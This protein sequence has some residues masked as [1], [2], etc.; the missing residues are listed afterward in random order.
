[1]T[2]KLSDLDNFPAEC[3]TCE[4]IGSMPVQVYPGREPG[5][6]FVSCDSDLVLASSFRHDRGFTQ[7]LS[8]WT[9]DAE[10]SSKA[11]PAIT[12]LSVPPRSFSGNEANVPLLLVA[13]DRIL[14]AELEPQVRPVQR[15][16]RLEATPLKLLYSHVLRCLV[17]AVQTFDDKTAIRF[18]DPETGDDLSLPSAF[19]N[20]KVQQTEYIS[21]LGRERDRILC[22]EEWHMRPENGSYYYLLISTR[23]TGGD[24]GGRVLVVHPVLEKSSGGV[25]GQVRFHTK[26]KLDKFQGGPGAPISA[27]A[28]S[29]LK[30]V[31]STGANLLSYELDVAAK[32]IVMEAQMDLGGPA[33]KLSILPGGTRTMALVK[34]DSL[35]VVEQ[36][37]EGPE[38]TTTHIEDATRSAMDMLEVAGA[39]EQHGSTPVVADPPQS[40]V[41][42]SDQSCNLTG[43]WVPWNSPGKDCEV[44]FEAELPSSVRRLR[45][46]RTLPAWSRE[47]RKEPKFGLLPASVDNAQI[48]GMGIDGSM[49]SFTL[50]SMDAWRF[51]R[52]VQNLA[53]TS[54]ELYPFTY[55]PWE[56]VVS[57]H[58]GNGNGGGETDSFDPTPVEDRGL[59]MQVDGDMLLRCL[60]K[61]A[62]EGLVKRGPEE[63]VDMFSEY[64]RHIVEEPWTGADEAGV[65]AQMFDSAYEVLEYYLVPV[66]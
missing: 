52:F 42:L 33:W 46:G 65:E 34:G 6:C 22:L 30:I 5:S 54:Q 39:W 23:G 48:L 10:D 24:R 57:Q 7:K 56:E 8:V 44:L 21:G 29:G 53:E 11:S 37:D 66:I 58:N 16:I 64:L 15:H 59:E 60:E 14:F 20:G 50:L 47:V 4:R 36:T 51:L 63:W 13:T 43:L 25:R 19:Y 41:L 28:A 32:K 31:S 45:L 17:V 49:Q 1:M 18:I 62:L 2:I 9:V 35:R 40:I 3:A 61:R 27:I 55:V 12:T 26:F 38:L